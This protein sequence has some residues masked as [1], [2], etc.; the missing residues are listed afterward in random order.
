MTF[1]T[2]VCAEEHAKLSLNVCTLALWRH[3]AGGDMKA[4]NLIRFSPNIYGKDS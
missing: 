4:A 1:E 3:E 2:V